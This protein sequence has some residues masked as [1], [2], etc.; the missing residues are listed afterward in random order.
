M[1]K[2]RERL[3]QWLAETGVRVDG[4]DP[5][6]IQVR[7]DRFY[8]RVLKDGSLGLGESYMEGWWDCRRIDE[9]I[10][11]LL[12]GKLEEKIRGNLLKYLMSYISAWLFNLQSQARSG[13]VARRHYDLENELFFSFLDPYNQICCA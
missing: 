5:W 7:D 9:F 2:H 1:K 13:I 6:D 11:R 10:Y 3:S 12:K 8:A 4:L